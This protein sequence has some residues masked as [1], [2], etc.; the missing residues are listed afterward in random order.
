M[1][2]EKIEKLKQ[3][4][5]TRVKAIGKKLKVLGEAALA[6]PVTQKV[7]KELVRIMLFVWDKGKS[8]IHDFRKNRIENRKTKKQQL[9]NTATKGKTKIVNKP[10]R[11]KNMKNFIVRIF[12]S[13]VGFLFIV[14]ISMGGAMGSYYGRFANNAGMY[15][16]LG[17]TTGFIVAVFVTG[18]IYTILS[19]NAHLKDIRDAVCSGEAAPASLKKK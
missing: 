12:E 1:D 10:K 19:I 2:D 18:L 3:Q 15:V 8:A 11:G 17:I 16:F 9:A 14:L 5:I 13:M 7:L 6:S 4:A